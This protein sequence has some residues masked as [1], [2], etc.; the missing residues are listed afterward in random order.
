MLC[1]LYTLRQFQAIEGDYERNTHFCNW[2][3]QTVLDGVLDA[4][5]AF[6]MKETCFLHE[7][8]ASAQNKDTGAISI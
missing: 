8:D 3:L 7:W 6:V 2:L 1:L 5:F 4:E